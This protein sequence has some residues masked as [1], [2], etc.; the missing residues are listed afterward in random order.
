MPRLLAPLIA[1]A[2]VLVALPGAAREGA[3]GLDDVLSAPFV[4]DVTVAPRRD[5][6]TWTIHERGARNVV[7]WTAGGKAREVTHVADDDGQEIDA[8]QLT[9]DDTAVVYARGGAGQDGGGDDPNPAT[10]VTHQERRILVTSV[11]TGAT[12]DAGKGR[13]PVLSPG[14]DRIA[15]IGADN[16]LAVATIASSDG[17]RTWTA[18]TPERPFRL[19]GTVDAPLWSPDGTRIAVVTNRGDHAYVA[20]YT[21]GGRSIVY[22]AP[23]FGNDG[24]AAWSPDSQKIAFVRLPGN[25]TNLTF[26]DDPARYAP[27]SIVV[28]DA[29]SG[30][31]GPVW[32]APRGRGYEFTIADGV[33]P[34]WWSRGGDLAFVWERDGWRHLYALR[35]GAG[36]PQLLTPGGYEIEQI[37]AS[38]DGSSLL[39][40]SNEGDLEARHV[41]RVAF[42]GGAPVPVTG[43]PANQWSPVDLAGGRAAYIDAS[44]DRPGTVTLGKTPGPAANTQPEAVVAEGDG[45]PVA[46]PAAL[47]VEPKRVAFTAPDGLRIHGQLFVPRG[48]GRHPALIFVHGGPERQMLTTFHYFEAYTNLYELNEYLTSLGFEV[49]S[50]NYRSGIMYGHD[51]YE[52]PK[53]GWLGA[54]EYQD[55]L[56]GAKWLGAR[57]DVDRRRLGIYGLSYGGYLTALA[58]ARNSDVFAAGADQAGVHD[59]R[60]FVDSF[61]GHPVGTPQQRAI[62]FASSPMASVA[63]WRSPVYLSQGDD[64]RN[65]AFAQGVELANALEARGATVVTSAVPDELHEYAVYAHE[66]ARFTQTANFLVAHI[67][68]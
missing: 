37:S 46:F 9:P 7:V 18:G 66:L 15:W 20:I 25:P 51:F 67:A 19:R 42:A 47:L 11:A 43:G 52:P 36:T 29:Q 39:Y 55:V 64:D 16:Q 53:R 24:S 41:W 63:T 35:H 34:L 65:V 49:L 68:Q 21:L 1:A 8:P 26:Y 58:L 23:G 38:A 12:I 30:A 45:L 56:A 59:W 3:F 14:G 22:A 17:G 28:A 60:A 61:S 62:A 32:T 31:G 10:P 44:F 50:V 13:S 40:T 54:S 2:V 5:A 57:R 4:D 48:G 33:Q 27:W 6:L